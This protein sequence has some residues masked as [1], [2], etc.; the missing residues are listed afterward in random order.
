[1]INSYCKVSS[2][3]GNMIISTISLDPET[4][5]LSDPGLIVFPDPDPLKQLFRIRVDPAPAPQHCL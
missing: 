5:L 2:A 1:M 4:I 3:E